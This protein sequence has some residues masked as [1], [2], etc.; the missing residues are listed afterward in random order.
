[1][2][3]PIASDV[4]IIGAGTAG[5]ILASELSRDPARQVTLLEA[6]PEDADPRLANPQGWPLLMGS[7]FDWAY[8]T[9]P[10]AGLDDRV[11][12][13][14]RGRVLGGS[15]SINALG[16]QRG[17]P[18]IFDQWAALG[19]EGWAF[20]DLLPAFKEL[21][22]FDGGADAWRGGSGPI[23]VIRPRE[24][25]RSD[26]AA[27]FLEA[28][29]Q[30][31]HPL[32]AD[33]NGAQMAGAAWNQLA[34]AGGRRASSATACLHAA[35]GR[36]NLKVVTGA[37]VTGLAF[38]GQ[39]CVG[40][41]AWTGGETRPF[42]AAETVLC[43]GAIDTP[44]LLML[45]G[46]GEPEA[47]TRLGLTVKAPSPHV[48]AHLQD[49]PLCGI[50]HAAARPLPA[51]PYNHGEA[52]VFAHSAG[53]DRAPDIQ[54]MAVDVPFATAETGPGPA[55]GFSLVPCLMTPESRGAVSLTSADARAPA[56]IDPNYLRVPEDMDRFIGAMR[57]AREIAARPALASWSA[58]E[59]LPGPAAAS[60]AEL[61]AYA[62]KAV[63]PF[64]HPVGT[65]RMGREGDG[66]VDS[67]L[68]VHGVESLRVADAAIIPLI[69]NAMP[70]AAVAA[71]ALRAAQII[72]ESGA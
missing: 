6:G 48:G 17:H 69:P 2:P 36:P 72:E 31:G 65:C 53:P 42:R 57:R 1:M 71:I 55:G 18:A 19:C 24:G 23:S 54:I 21:E 47:L 28:A 67:R 5:A 40:A 25:V 50:A 7:A 26:F 70:N 34:I 61:R 41:E 3:K 33:F 32:T 60:D 39:R 64:Y 44:R 59:C 15:S 37:L 12:S 45:S 49:H 51:S 43:A 20:A 4:L 62:R 27:A 16:H 14:P 22:R 38:E 35:R 9:T 30:A 66:V 68:R 13:Y 11:L 10:Q 8:V 52:I 56:A 63:T 29:V 46:V 58:G